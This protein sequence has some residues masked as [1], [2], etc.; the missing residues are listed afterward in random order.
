M[1]RNLRADADVWI[2]NMEAGSYPAGITDIDPELRVE[3]VRRIRERLAKG[4]EPIRR[5][6]DQHAMAVIVGDPK[7]TREYVAVIDTGRRGRLRARLDEWAISLWERFPCHEERFSS[8]I[9][10]PLVPVSSGKRG[11]LSS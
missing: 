11:S 2:R 6:L 4:S 1:V 10:E 7:L 3:V 5:F 9:R 8:R